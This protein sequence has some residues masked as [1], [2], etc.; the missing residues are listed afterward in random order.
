MRRVEVKGKTLQEAVKK[1]VE[2]L[3]QK[4]V[5]LDRGWYVELAKY[6]QASSIL[7]INFSPSFRFDKISAR[8]SLSFRY[9][10]QV[11]EG[12]PT[13]VI[14]WIVYSTRENRENPKEY[15]FVEKGINL[16]AKLIK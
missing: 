11:V 10:D 12:P 15:S 8:K 1:V 3:D 7:E 16:Q 5:P 14:N 2:V 4:K 9:G 6:S 13:K